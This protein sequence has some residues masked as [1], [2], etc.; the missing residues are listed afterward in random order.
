MDFEER[1]R[2]TKVNLMKH[3][4]R[5]RL[6]LTNRLSEKNI[7]RA[8]NVITKNGTDLANVGVFTEAVLL[9]ALDR[10]IKEAIG[11]NND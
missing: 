8:F 11:E 7:E 6:Q 10:A 4:I 1:Q 3:I 5:K 9:S 2:R